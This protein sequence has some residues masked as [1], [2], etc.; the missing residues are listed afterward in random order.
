MNYTFPFTAIVGMDLVKRSLL[1][2]AI[3]PRLGG[4]LLMGHR[5]CAKSTLARAFREILP[6][7]EK[8]K[9]PPFVEVPLGTTE[10]RLLGSIDASRLLENGEWSAQTGLI[11]QADSGVLYIDEV[12]L[13]PDHLVD[14]ILDSAASGQHRIERDGLSKTVN[15]RYILIGSMNPEEGDLR[16]QLTDRFMHGILIRDDFSVEQRREIVRVR[17]D[18]DDDPQ[19]FLEEHQKN[20][21]KLKAQIIEVRQQ[22][23]NVEIT[24]NLR[25]EVAEK[26]TALNLEGVRAE[27]GVLRTVRC[28]AAWRGETTVSAEDLAEAWILCLGHRQENLPPENQNPKPEIKLP[29]PPA[30]KLEPKSLQMPKTSA[31]PTSAL[32]EN[33]KLENSQFLA[34]S[35]LASWWK[36]PEKKQSPDAFVSGTSR[37]VPAHVSHARLCWNS[38]LKASLLRGWSPG[39]A[40]HLRFRKPARRPNFW[41]FIDA[42]RSA[43]S[44]GSGP[45]ARF[46]NEAR[47]AILTLGAKT[48]GSRFHVLVLQKGKLNWWIK[49]GTAQAVRKT[50]EQI[51][52]AAGKSHLTPALNQLRNAIQKQGVLIGDRVLLC[53][54]GMLSPEPEKTVPESKKRFRK[55]LLSLSERVRTTAWLYPQ[56]Q[57][58]MRHWL[59]QLV[60]GTEVRLIA[61]D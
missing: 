29:Q 11:Q 30:E 23:K 18:F 54:D 51:T 39:K 61:L 12:N 24:E 41:L 53:S 33:I 35:E 57:R 36:S 60:E 31:S 34:H 13:L 26:A 10:D 25:T 16:P 40:W 19:L 28:A 47:N 56:L 43:G 5:G 27:L 38:S 21:Q 17:M 42:S 37:P 4:L 6:A 55:A 2:H 48:F 52:E 14:S 22:L 32:T 20:L 7:A 58:G 45:S 59:P 15:A 49:H 3:D 1:Y 44:I 8:A 50:L 9:T 46:L